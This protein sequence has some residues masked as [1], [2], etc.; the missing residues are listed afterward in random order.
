MII[1]RRWSWVAIF[2]LLITISS[3]GYYY[4]CALIFFQFTCFHTHY[5]IYF[6]QM[7]VYLEDFIHR[8]CQFGNLIFLPSELQNSIIHVAQ[9]N[10]QNSNIG[11]LHEYWGILSRVEIYTARACECNICSTRDNTSQY[12]CTDPFIVKQYNIWK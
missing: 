10:S 1:E 3:F 12:S 6:L 2:V 7:I 8:Y 9:K 11:L 5:V 4:N